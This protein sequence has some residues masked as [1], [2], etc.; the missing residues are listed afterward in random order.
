M[1]MA[2]VEGLFGSVNVFK[3]D[4]KLLNDFWYTLATFPSKWT[5][6]ILSFG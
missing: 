6:A 3:D 5:H 2:T 4:P 1:T